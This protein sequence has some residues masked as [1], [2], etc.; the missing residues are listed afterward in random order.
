M[1]KKLHT[2]QYFF[3]VLLSCLGSIF[4]LSVPEN[5][6]GGSAWLAVVLCLPVGILLN[7]I[8]VM[9]FKRDEGKSLTDINR[10]AFGKTA[11]N[12]VSALYAVYFF[13]AA[14]TLLAY[15]AFFSSDL[16][17]NGTPKEYFLLVA[18]AVTAYCVKKGLLAIGRMGTV[19]GMF[20]L[21]ASVIMLSLE[22][23]EA[24]I[25]RLKF[26][27]ENFVPAIAAFSFLQFGELFS[28]ISLAPEAEFKDNMYKT[29]VISIVAG[30]GLIAVFALTNALALGSTVSVQYAAFYRVVRTI[31]LGEFLN[32][33][34]ALVVVAYF[35]A[36]VFRVMLNFYLVCKCTSDILGG[37][38]ER[39]IAVFA[40]A[41]LFI[42]SALAFGAREDILKYYTGVYPY[43]SAVPLLI[44]P[45]ITLIIRSVQ[46]RKS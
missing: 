11:G 1:Q 16:I 10:L 39:K 25:S 6:A 29:T 38:K 37:K 7:F 20:L 46:R 34:E 22:L 43:I 28:V 2:Y 13:F 35:I 17:L 24:D 33:I 30:N 41:L 18:A 26:D 23:A 27:T 12:A 15:Y 32:R 21:A 3:L 8:A 42:V 5:T 40:G 31:E 36:T 19:F 14:C 45:V 9:L 44:L 4:L